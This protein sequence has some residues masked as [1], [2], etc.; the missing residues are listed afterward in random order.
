MKKIKAIESGLVD[1]LTRIA[2]IEKLDIIAAR[3]RKRK[4]NELK[5]RLLKYDARILNHE[6]V[7]ISLQNYDSIIQYDSDC[8]LLISDLNYKIQYKML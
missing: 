6:F 7:S 4:H 5:R 3:E 8:F 2:E 1:K